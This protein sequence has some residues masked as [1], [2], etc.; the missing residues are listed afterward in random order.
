MGVLAK[1]QPDLTVLVEDVYK[2]H[3]LSAIIR[4]CDAVGISTVRAINPTG[5]IPTYNETSASAKK[6]VD[7]LVYKTFAE[8]FQNLKGQGMMIYAAQLSAKACD[9]RQVDY[10][11]PCAILLGNEKRGVS[12]EAAE[13]ADK[14][15]TIPMM[16]MVQSLNVSVAAAIVLFEAQK[17]RQEAGFYSEPRLSLSEMQQQALKWGYVL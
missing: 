10:K 6:W 3:N 12:V 11:V 14:H 13:M 8:A 4:S 2:P 5:G 17:Q 15:I 9:Y 16:G 7:L 1:R